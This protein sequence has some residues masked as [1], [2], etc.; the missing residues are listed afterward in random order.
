LPLKAFSLATHEV[1]YAEYPTL[2]YVIPVYNYLWNV[3]EDYIDDQNSDSD[4]KA[5][6]RKALDKLRTY[7][8]RTGDSSAY[9]ITT[10]K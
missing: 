1:S 5:A 4:I 10:G 8:R 2:S 7:Y 9:T 6:A 3:V